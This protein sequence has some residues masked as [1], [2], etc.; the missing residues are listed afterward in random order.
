MAN[1]IIFTQLHHLLP[2]N[3]RLRRKGH[4][5]IYAILSG[6]EA[7]GKPASSNLEKI[8]E[9]RYSHLG[10]NIITAFP[11]AEVS[12]ILNKKLLKDTYIIFDFNYGWQYAE[13]LMKMGYPGFFSMKWAYDLE[14]DRDT[15]IQFVKKQ[16]PLIQLPETHTIPGKA[17]G[18]FLKSYQQKIWVIKPNTE[19]LF[20][21]VPQSEEP[22]LAYE[23]AQVYLQENQEALNKTTVIMQEKIIGTEVVCETGYANGNPVWASIDLENKYLFPE[24]KGM[25]TGC[26]FDLTQ[27]IPLN[28]PIREI[29][30]APF[31]KIAKQMNLTGIMDIDVIFSHQNG[32][33]YFLEFC[34]QRFGYNAIFSEWTIWGETDIDEFLLKWFNGNLLIDDYS[35]YGASIRLFNLNYAQ[36][37]LKYLL[38]DKFEFPSFLIRSDKGIWLWDVFKED[39]TLKLCLADF[40]TAIVTEVSDTP[41]GALTRV[42]RTARFNIDFEGKYYRS[43]IDE[44]SM[45]YNPAWRYEFLVGKKL[46]EVF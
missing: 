20:T 8:K 15:S 45:A 5:V 29:L 16:Y 22:A 14:R 10:E 17:I 36:N 39:E 35:P 6:E 46:L 23:E 30:N 21:F 33:P 43:D 1:F 37:L 7:E 18:N 34:P 42:K 2:L 44:F 32:K 31:D 3:E 41:E 19:E 12:N 27:F 11:A 25:Q 4:K 13:P 40:N 24:E 26:S 9:E 38:E 28:A